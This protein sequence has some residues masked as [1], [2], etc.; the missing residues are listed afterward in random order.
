MSEYSFRLSRREFGLG[1][2]VAPVLAPAAR[3]AKGGYR[4]VAVHPAHYRLVL[5][6]RRTVDAERRES[7]HGGIGRGTGA[8]SAHA[9]RHPSPASFNLRSHMEDNK[10][11]SVQVKMPERETITCMKFL[12][13]K[14]LLSSTGEVVANADTP[15]GCRTKIVTRVADARKMVE[16]WT[17][18]LHRVIFY[19]DHMEAAERMGHLMGF[20]VKKE[21]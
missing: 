5:H 17:G 10:G 4:Q 19:G 3:A 7:R 1:L 8:T 13:P 9:P 12:D 2:G 16:G 11:V 15:R 6:K 18:G 14:I 20:R 21:M